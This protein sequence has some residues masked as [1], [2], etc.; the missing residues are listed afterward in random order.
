MIGHIRSIVRFFFI[1]LI[2]V[3]QFFCSPDHSFWAKIF[4]P[5]GFCPFYPSCSDYM[6]ESITTRGIIRGVC[7]GVWRICR[8]H[9]W[10]D[11][12]IDHPPK[13]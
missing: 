10:T 5:Q 13:K 11:G 4:F 6:K 12:G 2:R 7:L 3:Y 8:C 9:P 1:V